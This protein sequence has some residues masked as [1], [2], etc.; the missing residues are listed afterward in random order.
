MAMDLRTL[1]RVVTNNPEEPVVMHTADSDMPDWCREW[2]PNAAPGFGSRYVQHCLQPIA[3][4]QADPKPNDEEAKQAQRQRWADGAPAV[5]VVADIIEADSQTSLLDAD[6]P[7]DVDRYYA[8]MEHKVETLRAL[9]ALP[10]EKNDE[11]LHAPSGELVEDELRS[12]F[13][14]MRC[15][16][17]EIKNPDDC[18]GNATTQQ[19]AALQMQPSTKRST[20]Q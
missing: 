8:Y 19:K 15:N 6:D 12:S 2:T 4:K 18:N 13:R 7:S 1:E 9:L 3:S 11:D 14:P 16:D 17:P 5:K 10:D 20:I